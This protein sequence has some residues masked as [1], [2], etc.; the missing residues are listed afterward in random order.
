VTIP[1]PVLEKII[2]AATVK[3]IPRAK[4]TR[5]V[6]IPIP[7]LEKIIAAAT[8]KA[9]PRAKATRQVITPIPVLEKI[10]NSNTDQCITV[11]PSNTK[12]N[13]SNPNNW[14]APCCQIDYILESLS[15]L[16]K[17]KYLISPPQKNYFS[18]IV[19]MK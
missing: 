11:F 1:I 17:N 2:A 4:A 12:Q 15:I 13:N 14:K 3:A 19:F 7:V 16:K 18:R 5:Q 9:I 10:K 8:V 6:T